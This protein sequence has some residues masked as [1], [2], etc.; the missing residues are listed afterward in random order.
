MPKNHNKQTDADF[1][2]DDLIDSAVKFVCERCKQKAEDDPESADSFEFTAEE[3]ESMNGLCPNCS[4]PL[5]KVHAGGASEDEEFDDSG[6]L[7]DDLEEDKDDLDDS[8]VNR[9]QKEEEEE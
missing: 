8:F 7:E 2:E 4:G 6:D 1:V 5:K 3:I 9:Y